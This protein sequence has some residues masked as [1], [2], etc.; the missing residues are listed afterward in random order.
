MSLRHRFQSCRR[1]R[2]VLTR[3]GRS[4]DADASDEP[5]SFLDGPRHEDGV[6]VSVPQ[7]YLTPSRIGKRWRHNRI[8]HGYNVLFK[9]PTSFFIVFKT[10]TAGGGGR[11]MKAD[12]S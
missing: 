1:A 5:P 2:G 8:L 11:G 3:V 7:I 10:N 6:G 9:Q 12:F 4:A